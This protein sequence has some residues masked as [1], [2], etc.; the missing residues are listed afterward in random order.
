MFRSILLK[1]LAFSLL[2][3]CMVSNTAL[4]DPEDTSVYY[5]IDVNGTARTLLFHLP[6]G[7]Q[8]GD[9][10]P[11]LFDFHGYGSNAKD[12]ELLTGMSAFADQ[13]GFVV[14]YPEGLV[15]QFGN[16]Y[17]NTLSGQNKQA[18]LDF[19]AE[20]LRLL[21]IYYGYNP[22]RVYASGFSNGGGMANMLAGEMADTFAAIGTVAG[23]YYD[24]ADY[25][26]SQPVPVITFHGTADQVVPYNG[27]FILPPIYDWVKDWATKNGCGL[28]AEVIT[29][30]GDIF[31]EQW[32]QD[33]TAPVVLYSM[34]D[35]GHSWPGSTMP[36]DITSNQIDASLRM[37]QFFAAHPLQQ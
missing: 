15:D 10:L 4:A 23:A 3:L 13:F 32:S 21:G 33:C 5:T 22:T 31:A 1:L 6:A 9:D 36:A 29:D 27:L 14:I 20:M 25:Q 17:W 34:L 26:P 18:D 12:Q 35:K 2:S 11:V 30:E 7:Y 37:L 28:D 8:A 24:Y 16:Q 19:V